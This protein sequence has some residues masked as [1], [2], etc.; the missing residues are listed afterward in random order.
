V[1]L[2]LAIA[3]FHPLHISVLRGWATS[4]SYVEGERATYTALFAPLDG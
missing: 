3:F 4:D 1:K 2:Q